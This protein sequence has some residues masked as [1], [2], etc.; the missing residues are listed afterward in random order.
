MK[1]FSSLE[2]WQEF[3]GQNLSSI[4]EW[5]PVALTIGNFDGVHLGHQELIHRIRQ[6]A[7]AQWGR[8]LLLTFH[9][10]P[11][12]VLAPHKEHLRL[13][14]LTDQQMQLRQYGL[15]ILFRQT[16]TREFSELSAPDFLEQY[17]LKFFKPKMIAVGYNFTFGSHRQGNIDLLQSFCQR[18]RIAL[19]V[20]PAYRSAV[21][22]VSTSEIR[23]SLLDGD[24]ERASE[25]LGRPY[26]LRGWVKKGDERGRT[27]GFPTANLQVDVNFIPRLGVYACYV[28]MKGARLAAVMNIGVNKTFVEGE[29]HPIKVEV[30]IL[31]F[32]GDIYGQ[33]MSVHFKQFLRD[34][35]RFQSIEELKQQI[36][37]DVLLARQILNKG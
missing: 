16:F 18:H 11:V 35:K 14:S 29:N 21:G 36:T 25:M 4:Q 13:F 33:E 24:V 22:V 23:R 26:C 6:H 17:L 7:Q 37:A 34:E 27:I 5:P 20:V 12:Q 15:D 3:N 28:E 10:H 8:S 9:P 2:D 31:D 32:S 30:H 1:V 19:E